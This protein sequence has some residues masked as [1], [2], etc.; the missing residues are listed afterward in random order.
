MTTPSLEGKVAL[1]TGGS[2]GIGRA[3]C[4]RLARAGAAIAVNYH[5]RADAA[6]EVVRSIEGAGGRAVSIEGDVGDR[7]AVARMV[8]RVASELGPI[9]VLVNNA[10]LLFSGSLLHYD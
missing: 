4:L 6:A 2:R 10:G 9:D 8:E 7:L 3:I 1:V 5:A